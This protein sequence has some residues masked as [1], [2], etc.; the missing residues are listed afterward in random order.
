MVEWDRKQKQPCLLRQFQSLDR[1]CVFRTNLCCFDD[2]CSN[3][4]FFYLGWRGFGCSLIIQACAL[5]M[6]ISTRAYSKSYICILPPPPNAGAALE[7]EEGEERQ[8]IDLGC[9]GEGAISGSK[10]RLRR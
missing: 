5:L 9:W 7:V 8:S 1:V 10:R 6:Y 4:V 2:T 3:N